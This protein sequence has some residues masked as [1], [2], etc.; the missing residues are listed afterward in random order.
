M[1]AFLGPI[2]HWLFNKI[3]LQQELVENILELSNDLA[4]DLREELNK[5]YDEFPNGALED[6]V[7]TGN[8]HGW[9]QYYVT[10]VEYKLAYSVTYLLEKSPQIMQKIEVLFIEKGKEKAS[11]MNG[12]NAAVAYKVIGDSLLDGMPCDHANILIEENEDKVLWKRNTCVHKK[13]W[14]EVGGSVENYYSLRE[15]FIE[16][17]LMGTGLKYEKIDDVTR[18][19]RK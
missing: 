6:I 17:A 16:G 2:H 18:M 5:R 10:Q 3:Q 15:A 19:I 12:N 4:P 9:L 11:S 8:I 1:S 7:D 13:Y 14:D